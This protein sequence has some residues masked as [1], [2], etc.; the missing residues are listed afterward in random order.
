[1]AEQTIKAI[2]ACMPLTNHVV[3]TK[4]CFLAKVTDTQNL[5]LMQHLNCG[6]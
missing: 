5:A 3:G 4:V 2:L 6:L 1:M